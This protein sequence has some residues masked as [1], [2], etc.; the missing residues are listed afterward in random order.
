ME[1]PMMEKQFM[2]RIQNSINYVEDHLYEKLDIEYIAKAAFMSQSSFYTIFSNI[3]DT[4]IKDYIRKRRLSLSAYDLIYSNSS[5]LDL[6]LK[7]QYYTSESYS[8]SFKKLFGISPKK[9]KEMN[10]FV[11]VFPRVV[12][13]YNNLSGGDFMI[14]KEMNKDL[15]I[16]E[17]HALSNGYV[18]D[19]DIDGFM[20]VN[21]NYG[22]DIGDK[23]LIEVPKRIKEVL[24]NHKL[25]VDV[26]RISGDEFAV[27]IKDQS[28]SFIEQLSADII[29]IMSSDFIFDEVT[30]PITVSIGISDFTVDCN[31]E[32]AIKNANSAMLFA[33]INGRNQYKLAE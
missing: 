4:T 29:N 9:Y 10:I 27:I 31:N 22:Y 6:A 3:L 5:V 7:Y 1:V 28:R 33:K 18:L 14:S 30:L 11:N 16:K 32:A 19:I 12:L 23:V 17:I 2:D 26:V 8:R 21:D 25:D 20:K 24:N 13:Y 15:I